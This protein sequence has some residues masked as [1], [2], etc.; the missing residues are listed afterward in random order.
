M[1]LSDVSSAHKQARCDLHLC[2]V[3]TRFYQLWK[4]NGEKEFVIISLKGYCTLKNV[5][6]GVAAK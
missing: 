5:E 4:V 1:T 3:K 2:P 6:R